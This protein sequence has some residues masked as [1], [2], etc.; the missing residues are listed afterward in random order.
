MKKILISNVGN[1]NLKVNGGF[2]TKIFDTNDNKSFREQTYSIWQQIQKNEFQGELSPVIINEVIEI[3]KNNLEKVILIS[4]DMPDSQRNDQDTI[5]AGEI[6]CNIL[7]KQY[8]KIEFINQPVR[9]SVFIY[10]ELFNFYRLFLLNLKQENPNSKII[11]CDAGGTS[12]QKFALKISLEFLSKPDEFIVYYVAQ[13]EKGESKLMRGESYEY[14]KIIDLEHGIQAINSGAYQFSLKLLGEYFPNKNKLPLILIS[15]LELR[16]RLFVID[17]QK[18]AKNIS[19]FKKVP[20]FVK[21]YSQQIS[22]GK[23][24]DWEELLDNKQFF[25]LSEILIISQWKYSLGIIEQALHFFS[26][27]IEN[28]ISFI[29]RKH[30]GYKFDKHYESAYNKLIEDVNDNKITLPEAINLNRP[31]IPL[32][33]SIADTIENKKH[34]A[35]VSIIKEMNSITSSDKT[36]IDSIRNNYAHKGKGV[37]KEDFEKTTHFVNMRKCFEIFGIDFSK[38]YYAE[39]H[40]EVSEL[41]RN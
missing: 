16:S 33:I 25:L 20:Q 9:K 8:P 40:Y 2:I 38:N 5:Y 21:N 34:N 36:G 41:I 27:F 6:L 12:Q 18:L 3:E 35:L 28:Y 29:I 30:Y 23:Y 11:Y 1:R 4:S 39:M 7:R 14:R 13:Q 31:G 32:L 37:K 26:M 17:A 19:H 22:V 15:F 10:D 24:E